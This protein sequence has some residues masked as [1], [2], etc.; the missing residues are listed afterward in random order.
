[1]ET[2]YLL[3]LG[4]ANG[5]GKTTLAREYIEVKGLRYLGADQIAYELNPDNVESVAINAGR[6]FIQKIAESI[7]QHESFLLES[8]LSGLSLRKWILKA[9][10]SGFLI[11]IAF[12]YLDSTELCIERV[13]S[14]VKR[15]GHNVPDDD[16]AR[17]YHRSN[18][19]FWHSYRDL[20]NQWE[21]FNNTG[22]SIVSVATGEN[23]DI[24]VLDDERFERWLK[25]VMVKEKES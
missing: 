1:M 13:A 25:M 11:R 12:I 24:M 16:I 19:N 23:N 4:G 20:S 3:I 8:T 14:R 18:M 6:L 17:R 7:E 2:P 22:S 15:G 21:L 9:K 5:S 10:E